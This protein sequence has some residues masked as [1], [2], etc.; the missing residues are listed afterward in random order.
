M[1]TKRK[2]L[3]RVVRV[4]VEKS[5]AEAVAAYGERH[6]FKASALVRRALGLWLAST[7]HGQEATEP[8][9]H[10]IYARVTIERMDQLRKYRA[11]LH[12]K[13][14]LY[15]SMSDCIRWALLE[16]LKTEKE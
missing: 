1:K 5:L 8:R 4:D 16:Y 7:I 13:S 6:D 2:K 11:G 3:L 9:D 12:K 15:V 14:N 10:A